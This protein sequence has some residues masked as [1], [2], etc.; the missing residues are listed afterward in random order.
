MLRRLLPVFLLSLPL[1]AMAGPAEDLFRAIGRDD[2]GAIE[3]L[4]LRGLSPNVSDP[5][6][7]PALV[8]AAREGSIAAVRALL[9]SPATQIDAPN[10][11]GE[12]ALMVA[13]GAGNLEIVKLLVARKAQVNR[14]GWTPLHYAA[15]NGHREVVEYLLEQSAYI[16]A[17]SENGTTPLMLAARQ[18]KITVARL[19]VAEGADPTLRNQAG[20][21]AAGYFE[22]LGETGHADW[23]RAESQ[24]FRRRNGLPA[25]PAERDPRR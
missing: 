18:M 20:L 8:H 12:T 10:A 25:A 13:A 2:I 5:A 17:A 3:M 14:T 1:T 15:G 9:I 19:L 4:L 21:D 23:M 11:E 24:A 6:R 16:D 22:R 7:G